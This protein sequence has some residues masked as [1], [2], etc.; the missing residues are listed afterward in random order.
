MC[1]LPA[2]SIGIDEEREGSPA[3]DLDHRQELPVARLELRV[4]ADVDLLER[5]AELGPQR[6][7]DAA[8]PLAEVTPLRVEEDDVRYG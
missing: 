5:E 1:E 3:A 2:E 4:A 6:L 8:G 7:E